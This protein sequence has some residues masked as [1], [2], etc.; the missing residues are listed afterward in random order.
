LA[1]DPTIHDRN[2]QNASA[3][4]IATAQ[5]KSDGQRIV[6]LLPTATGRGCPELHWLARRST[7]N[8]HTSAP[9]PAPIRSTQSRDD[10][11]HEGKFLTSSWA[12]RTQADGAARRGFMA[13]ARNSSGHEVPRRP[14]TTP[15]AS[16]PDA[17]PRRAITEP[18]T[19]QQVDDRGDPVSIS[20]LSFSLWLLQR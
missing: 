7:M 2:S 18:R 11:E 5:H 14:L 15:S 8:R 13:T 10:A 17:D 3:H 16:W 6:S 4:L 12:T 1:K 19:A 9:P 20:L